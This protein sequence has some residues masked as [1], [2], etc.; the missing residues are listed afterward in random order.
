M[1]TLLQDIISTMDRNGDGRVEYNEF[2]HHWLGVTRN[3]KLSGQVH[4]VVG[5]FGPVY[6]GLVS[7]LL[8]AGSIVVAPS[9]N[10]ER[11]EMLQESPGYPAGLVTIEHSMC[12]DQG[13]A[14]VARFLMQDLGRLDGVVAHGG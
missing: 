1:T 13:A 11:I 8:D 10:P 5:S 9:A 4:L 3:A 12:T 2:L 7:R 14:E 6:Q